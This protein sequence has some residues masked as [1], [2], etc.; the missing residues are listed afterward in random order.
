MSSVTGQAQG[1]GAAHSPWRSSPLKA[2]TT[3]GMARA[4]VK[5]M[6]VMRAVGD[7][8]ADD[9]RVQGAG[10]DQVGDV[11]GLARRAATGSSRRSTGACR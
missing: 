4:S 1:M 7:R 2:A 8:A 5:S 10:H 6:L 9:G 3:P 11:A